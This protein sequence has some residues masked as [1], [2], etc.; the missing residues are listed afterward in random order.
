MPT[1]ESQAEM[2]AVAWGTKG[3]EF[4]LLLSVLLQRIRPKAL[5]ELGCGRSSTFFADYAYAL[6]AAY[7]GIENDARWVEKTELDIHLLGFGRRHIEHIPLAADGSWYDLEEFSRVTTKLGQF[8]FAF[9]DGPNEKQFFASERQIT[10]HFP[11]EQGNPFAYR[12]DADGLAA[13]KSVTRECDVMIVDD[14]H[15][16]HVFRTVDLMLSEP[17][18]YE[19][20][21]Y[22]YSPHPT[23]TNAL[24]ICL[25]RD[26]VAIEEFARLAESLGIQ[27]RRKYAPPKSRR[28]P[29]NMLS[30]LASRYFKSRG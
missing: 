24:C 26:K 13:V 30:R 29:R 7:I 9:I 16:E 18:R 6:D 3:F 2:P 25:K 27:L 11:P 19:K 21:Y 8:D 5:L 22:R 4:W 14:V 17:G 23:V 1:S 28:S 15:K 10:E 20:L 12:D